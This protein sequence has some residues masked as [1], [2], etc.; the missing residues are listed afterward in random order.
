MQ[1]GLS[2]SRYNNAYKSEN[3]VMNDGGGTGG[4]LWGIGGAGGTDTGDSITSGGRC[5]VNGG[6]GGGGAVGC[7]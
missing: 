6:G 4:A 5:L 7:R 3:G 2:T 1:Q